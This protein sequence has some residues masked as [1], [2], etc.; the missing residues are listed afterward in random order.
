MVLALLTKTKHV[1]NFSQWP[2]ILGGRTLVWIAK[3]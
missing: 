1:R 3:I 2:I